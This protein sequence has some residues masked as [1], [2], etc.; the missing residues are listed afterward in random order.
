LQRS[1]SQKQAGVIRQRARSEISA[2]QPQAFS[3]RPEIYGFWKVETKAGNIAEGVSRW[4]KRNS[5]SI[6][7]HL[8]NL[9]ANAI[10][11]GFT[12]NLTVLVPGGGT[13]TL[14]FTNGVLRAIQ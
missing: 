3:R 1:H 2:R 13:N 14:C 9:L 5:N 6:R 4:L 12:A 8:T 11:G 10:V 7:Y